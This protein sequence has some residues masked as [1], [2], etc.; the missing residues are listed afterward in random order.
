MLSGD[1]VKANPAQ[2]LVVLALSVALPLKA[3]GEGRPI[4]CE[5]VEVRSSA[6]TIVVRVPPQSIF[7]PVE[8]RLELQGPEHLDYTQVPPGSL[9]Q[10][11]GQGESVGLRLAL[12]DKDGKEHLRWVS[13]FKVVR[14]VLRSEV[15]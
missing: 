15:Q 10:L 8:I 5:V 13:G 11:V 14:I 3:K 12:V 6:H 7:S 9:V 2:V 4:H 1:V